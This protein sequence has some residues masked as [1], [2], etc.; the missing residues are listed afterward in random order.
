[1]EIDASAPDLNIETIMTKKK[2]MLISKRYLRTSLLTERL[3]LPGVVPYPEDDGNEAT[4]QRL[5]S[6]RL[7]VEIRLIGANGKCGEFMRGLSMGLART[8]EWLRGDVLA[9][10]LSRC[11]ATAALRADAAGVRRSMIPSFYKYLIQILLV[12][13]L[14]TNKTEKIK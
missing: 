12:F 1:M 8:G 7:H 13:F 4:D 2:V 11:K 3:E 6:P 5:P 9:T 14:K 10:R